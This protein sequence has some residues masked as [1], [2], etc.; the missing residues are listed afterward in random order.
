MTVKIYGHTPGVK[1]Q[2]TPSL[3]SAASARLMSPSDVLNSV[4]VIMLT[5][6]QEMKYGKK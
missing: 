5:T 6:S 4:N 3:P 1:Y 2:S